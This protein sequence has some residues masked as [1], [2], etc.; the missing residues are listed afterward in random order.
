MKAMSAYITTYAATD[1]VSLLQAEIA[2]N[3][4]Q[5]SA[6]NWTASETTQCLRALN[7]DAQNLS[8]IPA[9]PYRNSAKGE[10]AMKAAYSKY[11]GKAVDIITLKSNGHLCLSELK[12][13]VKIGGVG[14]FR[15]PDTFRRTVSDK[16]FDMSSTLLPD[17]E[18]IAPLRILSVCSVQ[19]PFAVSR[20]QS[21][22]ATN[23]PAGLYSSD[24]RKHDYLLCS[25]MS[26]PSVVQQSFTPHSHQLGCLFFSL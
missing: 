23:P 26:L 22:L 9:P 5:V 13:A 19:W 12:L 6:R 16:F 20:I 8:G 3:S 1:I 11:G 17:G 2:D 7:V 18:T 24:G 21:L 14:P 10:I 4:T 25:S 15:S